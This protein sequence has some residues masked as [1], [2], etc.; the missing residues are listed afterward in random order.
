MNKAEQNRTAP[1][2]TAAVAMLGLL[3]LA[4][5]ATANPKGGKVVGGNAQITEPDSKTLHVHQST[6]RAI[7]NWQSFNIGKS[8]TTQFFQPGTGSVTLN[9]VVGSQDP[10]R[11][12]GTLKANGTVMVVN[13][14]GILFGPDAKID[15]GGLVATTSD[16][17][18]RDFMA[19]SYRFTLPGRPD[20]SVINRGSVSIADYGIGAFVAPGVRNEGVIT[21]RLGSVGLAAA[22]TFTLDMYGDSLIHLELPDE[23]T[24]E[25]VDVATGKV[26]ADRVSN[27]GTIRA[28]GGVVALTAATARKVVNA[29]VNNTGVIEANSVGRR[30]GRIVLGAQTRKTKR[31]GAP[32]QTVKASGTLKASGTRPDEQG[33][34]VRITGEVIQLDTVVI[35]ADGPSGGGRILVGGDYMGGTGG[36]G[37][38]SRY[39]FSLEDEP[40]PT[41]TN[42]VLTE[43]VILNAD[44]TEVGN[45]GKVIVWSDDSTSTAA[46]ITA[47]G[48]PNGGDGGF[49][50]TSGRQFLAFESKVDT[51][52]GIL[53]IDPVNAEIT[54]GSGTKLNGAS[55]LTAASIISQLNSNYVIISTS[56]SSTDAGTI[57]VSSDLNYSSDFELSLYAHG[58]IHIGGNIQNSGSG[59]VS[60]VAG[61]DGKTI[62]MGAPS[63]DWRAGEFGNSNGT[64]YVI[65]GTSTTATGSVFLD[66]AFQ[67]KNVAFGSANGV[68]SVL[69]FDINL[70]GSSSNAKALRIGFESTQFD[71]NLVLGDIG[72]KSVND[73]NL[74]VN[75]NANENAL[76]VGHNIMLNLGSTG[77]TESDGEIRIEAGRDLNL[78]AARRVVRVGHVI[79]D[80]TPTNT[81]PLTLVSD[82]AI[83]TGGHVN[84]SGRFGATRIGHDA[85]WEG[86]SLQGISGD[87]Q[88]E[89]GESLTM[90]GGNTTGSNTHSQ[91][92][93]SGRIDN[94]IL[95]RL[96]SGDIS[97]TAFGP[98]KLEA[99]GRN[100]ST[101]IGH[102]GASNFRFINLETV[103]GSIEVATLGDLSLLGSGNSSATGLVTTAYA[104][105]GHGGARSFYKVN[106]SVQFTGDIS[107][108]VAG[109]LIL[110][111]GKE[112]ND[113]AQIGHGAADKSDGILSIDGRINL[114]VKGSVREEK[115]TTKI[116][117]ASRTATINGG[118]RFL[119]YDAVVNANPDN[120]SA[121]Q[122]PPADQSPSVDVDAVIDAHVA[123]PTNTDSSTPWSQSGPAYTP[124]GTF[125]ATFIEVALDIILRRFILRDFGI[126]SIEKTKY[127]IS[128]FPDFAAQ[129]K[130]GEAFGYKY[131]HERAAY[132]WGW[133]VGDPQVVRNLRNLSE[134]LQKSVFSIGDI[135]EGTRGGAK[136]WS[137]TIENWIGANGK[138]YT[139]D[140]AY[141]DDYVM[142]IEL[143]IAGAIA[144][145]LG[146]YDFKGYIEILDEQG[147]LEQNL[148]N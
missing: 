78:S 72:I 48:G 2:A 133:E 11:I 44:A 112:G 80:Q 113:Y 147:R 123:A 90:R 108:T 82:I 33:G 145:E 64:G 142:D 138:N 8:E 102:G 130:D 74:L 22:N 86:R 106:P 135:L 40:I 61:W 3:V 117:H 52:G 13:P 17:S 18:D 51:G 46:T 148:A 54:D 109:D 65:D 36:S 137:M 141:I 98:I 21:A 94:G 35:R 29:V 69:G 144:R 62:R 104:Q 131:A 96:L 59:N 25:V 34:K 56:E 24:G 42:V 136:I 143:V 60:A 15:V 125:G 115:A 9:R 103:S 6:D 76:A 58:D 50:E 20:A 43:T 70:V 146:R 122:I 91:I 87:I 47:R 73:V 126:E 28:D 68:T 124:I 27:A 129:A 1:R 92:G 105:L 55:E 89:V 93:H 110:A 85:N 95:N 120:A 88:I 23:L 38:L 140:A 19:G 66:S 121:R 100:G 84:L 134:E 31:A 5:P 37:L 97:I 32:V 128:I 41:A 132:D 118:V 7:I 30:G 79:T 116:E 77:S 107:A 67:S 57:L 83:K 139:V 39:G 26:L 49:V 45:G 111:G 71:E 119:N 14:D 99:Q 75:R 12:L 10:S 81:R 127:A 16:I 114:A 53:L 63:S 4:G 101:Q